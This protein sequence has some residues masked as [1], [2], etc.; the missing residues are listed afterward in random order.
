VA[1]HDVTAANRV[2]VDA[3]KNIPVDSDSDSIAS[4]CEDST[5]PNRAREAEWNGMEWNEMN[6]SR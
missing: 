6:V 4:R 3:M 2:A 1:T 5:E